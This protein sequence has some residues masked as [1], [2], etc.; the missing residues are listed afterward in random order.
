MGC[1]VINLVVDVEELIKTLY[2]K[3]SYFATFGYFNILLDFRKILSIYN[4]TFLMPME[5]RQLP[6]S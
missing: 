2:T 3:I 1:L 4:S 6:D 5:R